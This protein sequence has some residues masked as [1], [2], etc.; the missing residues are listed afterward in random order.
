MHVCCIGNTQKKYLNQMTKAVS[1]RGGHLNIVFI[2]K[3]GPSSDHQWED[4]ERTKASLSGPYEKG[5]KRVSCQKT[6]G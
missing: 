2:Y 4:P 3:Q 6:R 1:Q 5:G